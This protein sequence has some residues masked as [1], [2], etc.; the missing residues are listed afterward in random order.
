MFYI[1]KCYSCSSTVITEVFEYFYSRNS[2]PARIILR[3]SKVNKE[4][5]IDLFQN[6]V[7]LRKNKQCLPFYPNFKNDVVQ[8]LS[9]RAL[10]SF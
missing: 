4:I 5:N 8:K 7:L 6:I 2:V 1:L 10:P 3:N 9:W